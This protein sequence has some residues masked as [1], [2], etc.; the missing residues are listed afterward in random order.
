MSTENLLKSAKEVDN[1][2]TNMGFLDHL[3]ELR[4]R[5][6]KAMF[7]VFIF[8]IVAFFFV[9][10][11]IRFLIDP[12]IQLDNPLKLQVLRVQGMFIIQ[13]LT[14][15][16]AGL[17]VAIPI[18]VYQMWKFISP[19]LRTNERKYTIPIILVTFVNFL[20]G[21]SFAYYLV[22]PVALRFL[23][24]INFP[25]EV[26]PNVALDQYIMF[27]IYLIMGMG[28]VF[29]MPVITFILTKFRILTAPFLRRVQKFAVVVIF[30]LAAFFTPPDPISQLLMAFPLLILYEISIWVARIAKPKD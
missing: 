11:I 16:A 5:L 7:S 14:A 21:A 22:L 12:A 3:E 24:G 25:E 10:P 19:G 17:V 29:E 26:V 2:E 9:N 1:S 15:V 8:A 4:W 30:I 20:L 13:I 6:F 18:M 28:F 23:L 27:V